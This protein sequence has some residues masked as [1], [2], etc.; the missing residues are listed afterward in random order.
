MLLRYP[1]TVS[2]E[3][4]VSLE[5][6]AVLDND[7]PWRAPLQLNQGDD[8]VVRKESISSIPSG[9]MTKSDTPSDVVNPSSEAEK[10]VEGEFASYHA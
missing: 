3:L 4:A 9:S 1:E 6:K 5:P 8:N 2:L 7:V 10:K